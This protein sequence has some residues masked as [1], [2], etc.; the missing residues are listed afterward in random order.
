M[1]LDE[2]AQSAERGLRSVLH[3]LL[4][5]E[6]EEDPS[7]EGGDGAGNPGGLGG[8]DVLV[9]PAVPLGGATELIEEDGLADATEAGE[10]DA[11][12]EPSEGHPLHGNRHGVEVGI[13]AHQQWR[14]AA[15]A[16]G[17]RVPDTIHEPG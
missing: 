11:A 14:P 1:H 6:L 3:A 15:S 9:D 10:Q 2:G 16:R 7:G 5:A 17:E 13:A 4:E 8:L 12:L